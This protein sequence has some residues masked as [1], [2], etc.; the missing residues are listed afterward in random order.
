[1][2]RIRELLAPQYRAGIGERT[3]DDLRI[4]KQ[5]CAD[6]EHAVSYAR[7]LAQARIE[8]L[9]AEQ[10]RR[11]RGESVESL[12]AALPDILGAEPGR[13]SATSARLAAPETPA[14]ELRWPDGREELIGDMTLANLPALDDAALAASVDRLREFERELSDVRRDLHEVLDVI[15]RE[16]A[17]RQVAGAG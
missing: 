5:E 14:V 7:R 10:G 15:E 2:E 6:Y 17:T 16:I 11:A 13:S 3:L 1:M 12:V 4:M 9:E 8:I